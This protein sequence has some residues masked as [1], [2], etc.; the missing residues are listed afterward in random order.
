MKR[1]GYKSIS[2][3]YSDKFLEFINNPR[4]VVYRIE[5]RELFGNDGD[6]DINNFVKI[7]SEGNINEK[8]KRHQSHP[9][10]DKNFEEELLS[11]KENDNTEKRK[12]E[13][14]KNTSTNT[15]PADINNIK[16]NNFETINNDN[17]KS[18]HKYKT[19]KNDQ[20]SSLPIY[21]KPKVNRKKNRND[22]FKDFD[23]YKEVQDLKNITINNSSQTNKSKRK[24]NNMNHSTATRRKNNKK[25]EIKKPII[26]SGN[27][28]SFS[29]AKKNKIK[30]GK[31]NSKNDN[32]ITIII[33]LIITIIKRISQN[34]I[35]SRKIML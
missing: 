18:N 8:I 26:K 12:K 1:E 28:R 17:D 30:K 29:Q 34:L 23:F 25:E 21:I 33:I 3:L 19:K 11:F 2:D 20:K 24:I 15:N 5:D 10:N 27:N 22:K 6:K 9:I 32:N 35:K 14:E 7:N 4:N 16:N 31:R 13:K